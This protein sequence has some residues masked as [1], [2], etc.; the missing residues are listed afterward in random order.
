MHAMG[1]SQGCSWCCRLRLVI[2]KHFL[3]KRV[4]MHRRGLPR[5]E[6]ESLSLGVF[7]ELGCGT[8]DRGQLAQ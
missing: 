1:G 6:R 2:G 8:G 7:K 3:S 5:K 4:L